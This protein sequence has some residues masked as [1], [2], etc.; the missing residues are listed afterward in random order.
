MS[1]P[2][3]VNSNFERNIMLTDTVSGTCFLNSIDGFYSVTA[4]IPTKTQEIEV[5][6]KGGGWTVAGYVNNAGS[7]ANY[8]YMVKNYP[9]LYQS[10]VRT[11]TRSGRQ[12]FFVVYDTRKK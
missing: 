2:L 5:L 8:K 12:C 3:A 4:A 9:V 6:A 10:P 1:Q 11:S 7:K